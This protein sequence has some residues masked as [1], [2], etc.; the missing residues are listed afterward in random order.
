[1]YTRQEASLIK[2]R[3][4]TS[5]GQYMRPITAA[6]GDSINWVNYKTGVRNIYFRMDADINYASIAI[7]LTHAD[8]LMRQQNYEQLRQL[9]KVLEKLTGEE[10][11]W[12][13]NQEEHGNIFSRVSKTVPAVNILSESDWPD[14]IS[15][16]KPRIIALDNFWMMVKDSFD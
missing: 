4:W 8:S 12:Q 1:M 5:F 10:W 15:F 11:I 7:E 2:K 16:L 6:N 9:K 14:I 13:P 3:F